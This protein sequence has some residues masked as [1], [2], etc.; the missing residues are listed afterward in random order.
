MQNFTVPY[1][2]NNV[3]IKKDCFIEV[4]LKDGIITYIS[5]TDSNVGHNP[6]KLFEKAVTILNPEDPPMC[7]RTRRHYDL[8]VASKG[9]HEQVFLRDAPESV[10]TI[11]NGESDGKWIDNDWNYY[12]WQFFMPLKELKQDEFIDYFNQFFQQEKK[13]FINWSK[14]T[15]YTGKILFCFHCGC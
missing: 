9:T 6:N 8:V 5:I 1:D 12:F 13:T 14:E 11:K 15:V 4:E 2:N 7:A 10:Y 3:P